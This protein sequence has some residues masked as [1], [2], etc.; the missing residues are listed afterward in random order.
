MDMLPGMNKG[1]VVQAH[2]TYRKWSPS[3]CNMDSRGAYRLQHC[4]VGF[5][6]EWWR[7][8][9][10]HE[11]DDAKA[12]YVTGLSVRPRIRNDLSGHHEKTG[13]PHVVTERGRGG[14]GWGEGGIHKQNHGRCQRAR[15]SI[16]CCCCCHCWD[17][18]M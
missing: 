9:E 11:R 18:F 1:G 4:A 14:G 3:A 16:V 6:L 15:A 8:T 2:M 17:S 13:A 12:P 10:K 7:A 5:T